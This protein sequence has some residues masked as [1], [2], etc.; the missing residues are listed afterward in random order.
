M[1]HTT[2]LSTAFI[3]LL[4]L[5]ACKKS[6]DDPQTPTPA[7]NEEELITTVALDVD[8]NG[9]AFT[10][11]WS[12]IDG[13]GGDNPTIESVV[14][15]DSTEYSVS[16]RF[17]DESGSTVE[18]ITEEVK[19]EDDEHI[20]CFSSDLSA[21]SMEATDSDGNYPVGLTSKWT[22][23]GSASGEITISLKHQPNVKD[24]TCDPGETDVEVTFPLSID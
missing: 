24:G 6:D 8:G 10:V 13:P 2:I 22:T 4:F 7:T 14:L 17:L 23:I 20:V 15:A 12:D 21:I 1:K 18:D 9:D 19:S 11:T 5:N 3:G 16:V